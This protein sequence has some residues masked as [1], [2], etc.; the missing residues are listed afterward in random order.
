[1]K[2]ETLKYEH[3]Q[4]DGTYLNTSLKI[5]TKGKVVIHQENR[6]SSKEDC[7]QTGGNGIAIYKPRTDEGVVEVVRVEFDSLYEFL[8]FLEAGVIV[9]VNR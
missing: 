7:K 1:M 9:G 3:V 4:P 2:I 8:D 6:F 5:E